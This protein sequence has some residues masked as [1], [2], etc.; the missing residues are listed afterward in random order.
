MVFSWHTQ[1]LVLVSVSWLE[2][3]SEQKCRWGVAG[4]AWVSGQ[5][6][7]HRALSRPS[8]TPTSGLLRAFHSLRSIDYSSTQSVRV[9]SGSAAGPLEPTTDGEQLSRDLRFCFRELFRSL[10]RLHTVRQPSLFVFWSAQ[11]FFPII[12][13]ELYFDIWCPSGLWGGLIEVGN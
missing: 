11:H 9:S 4:R 2:Q 10:H 6:S 12:P 5:P 3:E 1:H 7:I 13:E 8:D